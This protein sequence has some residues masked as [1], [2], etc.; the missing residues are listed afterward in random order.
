MKKIFAWI[1]LVIAIVMLIYLAQNNMP[2]A[3]QL[4]NRLT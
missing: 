4:G 2:E 3:V 1:V